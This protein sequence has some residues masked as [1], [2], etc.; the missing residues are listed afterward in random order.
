MTKSFP[1]KVAALYRF[2]SFNQPELLQPQIAAWCAEHGLKGTILVATEGVNG[3]VAGSEAGIDAVVAH[4]RTLPGCAE[5]DVKYSHANEMPFYRMK[6]RLKKEIVTLGVDGIDPKREVGTYVQPEDWNA[7]ISDPDTVLI[8]T[9]ND[10]E[11]AIGTFEGAVDPRTKSFSE[12]PEWFRAHRDELAAG[13]TKFAMFCTGGIRC[14]K[15][16]AFLKAEGIDDVYHLEGGILRYLENIPEAESKW[17][18]ECFV[19][20]ERVSVKHGLA[21]GEMELCHA[22]RRPI[23]QEDKASAH[24]IEGVACPACYAER[25]DEDR[26]RFA[27]RQKQIALAKKRGKQHIGVNPRID[28]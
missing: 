13:K 5:L 2:A 26:A 11:V 8:D 7:L 28:D 18:G 22:C 16:T 4:L 12:F 19:F 20:D 6:V 14:E 24:F 10:Y 25:T 3:T 15:S 9:R 27:E 23:S 1:I 17:Q 21:L